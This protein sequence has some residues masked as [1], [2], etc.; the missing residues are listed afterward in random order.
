MLDKLGDRL[1]L[2]LNAPVQRVSRHEDGVT[3]QL[4]NGSHTFDQ[5]I[6]ACH[7]GRRWRC[8][9][10][11]LRRAR[12][13]G[14]I[15]WQRNEVVLH[16]DPRWLPVRQRA[17]ASWNYRL[18]DAGS[19]QRLRHLQHEYSPGAACGRPLFCVTLNPDA[20]VDERFVCSASFMSIRCLTRK[21]GRPRRGAK[22]LTASSGAGSAAPTGTTVFMKM[23]CAARSTWSTHRGGGG[24]LR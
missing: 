18:S 12:G 20:P 5:V 10:P 13:A 3:L 15:G 17:W 2:H 24:E 16:S 1:T 23:A 9:R 6:F 7:S 11:D 14:D 22:R 21:A 4:E 8:W 19:G